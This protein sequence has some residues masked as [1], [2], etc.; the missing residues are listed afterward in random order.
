MH[1]NQPNLLMRTFKSFKT[2]GLL[3]TILKI[4]RY[5]FNR[6]AVQ[7]KRIFYHP[8]IEDRFTE[9]Y[10][11]NYWG[12]EESVSGPGSTLRSTENL[13]KHLPELFERFSIK[14]IFDAPCGDFNWMRHV[15]KDY[16]INYTG[17]DIVLP[18]IISHNQ[19]YNND[20]TKF[21]HIDLTKQKFPSADLMI[22]RDCLFHLS[23][24]DTKVVLQ[25]FFR[26]NINYLLTTT[27][28]KSNAFLNKDIKTG[29]FRHIDLFSA[30]Y[31]FPI[32]VLFRIS[33]WLEPELEREMCLWSR[34]QII[35]ALKNFN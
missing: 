3:S 16:P 1:T 31:N 20:A 18:I 8:N 12:S 35:S 19:K 11:L 24:E 10:K 7:R 5:P 25:N 17:G 9:I 2:R 29:E 22:C 30:P 15:I 13:R 34:E 27:Y 23:Y 21:V 26:S 33:D 32:N 4:T 6:F 14:S 28:V